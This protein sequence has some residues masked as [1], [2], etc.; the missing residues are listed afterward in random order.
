MDTAEI[1]ILFL[2]FI[3]L[4][5]TLA[6]ITRFDQWWIRG[7][8]FPRIQISVCIIITLILCFIVY[9]FSKT[10]HYVGT[11]LLFLSLIY[12]CVKIF[13][14]TILA[15][16]QVIKYKGK[17][18]N[19]TIS[20]LVSNVLTPNKHPEKL[21]ALV[22][23]RQP[24]I[25]LT[26]E[27]DKRWEN[28]LEEIED[29]YKYTIKVP[30][31]NLY[32]MHLYSKL[33]LI[34]ADVHYLV[35]EDIP[36]I[37][38]YVKL[39]NG[40]KLKIHCLHPMPPSPTESYTSTNRDAEILMLGRD[41]SPEDRKVLVFGDLNDVAWSRTTKLFQQM[42]GLMDPRIGRGFFNTFHTGYR[43]FRW[44][45]D[46]VFH[47]KD[48]TLIEIAREKS[49]GSDHFPMY[50]KLNYDPRAA[51]VQEELE[52]EREDELW[53]HEKI[54]EAHPLEKSIRIPKKIR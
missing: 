29:D 50:I 25:L 11:I 17:E 37:H 39:R 46:H 15:K 3:F 33:E 23:K 18:D 13:P 51:A 38:G 48:F 31:D 5:P 2:N 53:A 14:Y 45:L 54:E 36:S 19:A 28:V 27:T 52:L 7:F 30:L 34:D 4:I 21:V 44:P 10:W 40:T 43:L 42:S 24:D 20:I 9:D 47:S 12:Q 32:G 41:L 6:S 16:K 22:K 1:I 26:L 49:I 8:D 35:Q